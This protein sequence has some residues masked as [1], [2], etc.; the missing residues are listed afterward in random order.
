RTVP[1]NYV[2]EA[3]Y[4]REMKRTQADGIARGQ[5]GVYARDMSE[6]QKNGARKANGWVGVIRA[7]LGL[8]FG[9]STAAIFL[10]TGNRLVE[11]IRHPGALVVGFLWLFAVILWSAVAVVRHADC[12][13]VKWGEPYGTLVLTLS[14]IAI[15]V[16]MI[17]AAMLHGQNNPALGRDAIFSVIMIA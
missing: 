15:E 16:V 12:L 14:A 2:L 8:I 17:S 5:T 6:K 13:A 9:I 11:I 3:G 7:E 10:G 4:D 1:G